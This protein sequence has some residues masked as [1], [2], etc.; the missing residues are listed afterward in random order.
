MEN[1]RKL[2]TIRTVSEIIPIPDADN[3]EIICIGGWKCVSKKGEF[4]ADDPCLYFEIDSFLPVN[5]SNFEFLRKT[6]YKVFKNGV[7]GFR[8]KSIKFRGVVSQGLALPVSTFKL[9][10]W[11]IGDDV[12]DQLG[13]VK[14]DPDVLGE[15]PERKTNSKWIWRLKLLFFK[16]KKFFKKPE[17][18]SFPSFIP[19]TDEERVQ[20]LTHYISRWE[21]IIFEETE[22]LDGTS[23]TYFFNKGVFGAC[24][25]NRQLLMGKGPFNNAA[26]ELAK[27]YDLGNKLKKEVVNMAIQGEIIGPSIQGNKYKLEKKDFFVFRIW[28]IDEKRYATPVERYTIVA[29][30]ELKHVPI[31]NAQA[32]ASKTIEEF[33][34]RVE[35][36]STLGH[37]E[38]EGHVFKSASGDKQISFKVINNKFLLKHGE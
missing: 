4:K 35:G 9:K 2:V 33:L 8:L 37:T 14:Y 31:V 10:K 7:E 15:L 29:N 5:N 3:I 12:T 32:L 30:F 18:K 21:G 28:L 26:W 6:S 38:K 1:E 22:K 34:V 16:I 23:T 19:K 27:Q 20:N 36:K 17:S 13:V 11:K 25:R 24:S